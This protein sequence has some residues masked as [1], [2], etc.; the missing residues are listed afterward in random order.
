M[1][2]LADYCVGDG[3][4]DCKT[5][6]DAAVA[7]CT[8]TRILFV[9]KGRYRFLSP[10]AAITLALNIVGE[11]KGASWLVRDYSGQGGYFLKVAGG[12]DPYGGGSVSNLSLYTGPL[13]SDGIAVWV[14]ASPDTDTSVLTKNPHGLLIDNIQIGRWS[15]AGGTW[16]YG[17]YLDGSQ[18][19]GP[20]AP[21]IRCV[22][23]R[24]VSIAAHTLFPVYLNTAIATRLTDVDA[25]V[26]PTVIGQTGSSNTTLTSG[27]LTL[28]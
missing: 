24:N 6:F 26:G 10:P 21:G 16:A 8:N 2:S 11:G 14:V 27:T 13:G 12:T 19:P 4:T 23:V 3:V 5:G 15:T 18:N 9:P 28:G 7:A 25:R 1:I 22:A 17:I 20:G